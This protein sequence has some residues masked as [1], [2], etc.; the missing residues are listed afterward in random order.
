MVTSFAESSICDPSF[1]SACQAST[2][3]RSISEI[4]FRRRSVVQRLV[5]PLVVVKVDVLSNTLSG[6]FGGV[7]FVKVNLFV[8]DGLP[9]SLG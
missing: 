2:F 1:L 5:W 6:L 3:S 7:V 4:Y 9:Q 8:L